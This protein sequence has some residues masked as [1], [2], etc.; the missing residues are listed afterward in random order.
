MQWHMQYT[1]KCVMVTLVLGRKD[2]T[3]GTKEG[4]KGSI[5]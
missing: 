3:W 1:Q 4:T 5:I 2:K